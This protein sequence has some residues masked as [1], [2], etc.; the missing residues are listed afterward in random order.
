MEMGPVIHYGNKMGLDGGVQGKY[1]IE[2]IDRVVLFL[3]V[4]V[5]KIG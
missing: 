2:N 1:T 5:H 4:S 3:S